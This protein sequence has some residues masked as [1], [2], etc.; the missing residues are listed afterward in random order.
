MKERKGKEQQ[1]E[2]SGLQAIKRQ[3]GRRSQTALL[4]PH[5]PAGS[6]RGQ[7]HSPGVVLVKISGW[8]GWIQTAIMIPW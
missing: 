3:S 7:K 2:S 8:T 4:C 5:S 1:A 6:G